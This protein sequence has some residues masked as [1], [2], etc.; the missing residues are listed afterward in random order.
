MRTGILQSL[1]LFIFLFLHG[2][3]DKTVVIPAD[4]LTKNEMV[5]LLADIHLAQATITIFEYTDTVKFSVKDY[6]RAILKKRNISEK[7]FEASLK[8]YSD[9]PELLVGI[10]EEVVNELSRKQGEIE[11][12]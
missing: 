4:I 9:H 8:F 3:K 6:Q 10:Y 11:K 1:I 12:K 7:K 2:C 5:P